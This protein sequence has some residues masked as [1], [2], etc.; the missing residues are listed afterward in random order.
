MSQRVEFELNAD[1]RQAVSAW[2]AL[3]RS[4]AAHNAEFAK[5]GPVTQ[6]VTTTQGNLNREMARAE[7]LKRSL[8][9][10]DQ[11]YARE[12]QEIL[13]LQQLGL[14]S[15]KEAYALTKRLIDGKYEDVEA[16]KRQADEQKRLEGVARQAIQSTTTAMERYRANVADLKAAKDAGKLTEEQYTRAIRQ[17]REELVQ[18]SGRIEERKRKEQEL[19]AVQTREAAKLQKLLNDIETAEDRA[20]RKR[21]EAKSLLDAGKISTDQY[22]RAVEKANNEL[23]AAS[24]QST[25]FT[26]SL[27]SGLVPAVTGFLSLQTVISGV[28]TVLSTVSKA[29][30]EFFKAAE[31]AAKKFDKA[32]RSFAIQANL[33]PEER[34][35]AEKRAV[36]I[37]IETGFTREKVSSA[38]DALASAGFSA[39]EASG[40][41]L[42]A[43]LDI[44]NAQGLR[45]EDPG[46][47]A[48]SIAQFL[49]A[50]DMALT[51]ENVRSVGN[52]IQSFGPD[53]RFKFRDLP[54]IASIAPV[55][56]G[57]A[58]V[59]EQVAV[60]AILSRVYDV[61]S[62][63]LKTQE[64]VN[65]LSTASGQKD[66]RDAL[67]ELGLKP[68]DV[69][70]I[71]EGFTDVFEKLD[72]AL[73]KRPEEDR[74]R[75]LKTLVEGANIG[76]FQQIA[77]SVPEIRE[78]SATSE[79]KGA[80]LFAPA[81]KVG[82]ESRDAIE[83]RLKLQTEQQQAARDQRGDL[84]RQAIQLDSVQRGEAPVAGFLRSSI[85]DAVTNLTGDTYQG[86]KFQAGAANVAPLLGELSQ[87]PL[88]VFGLPSRLY[89]AQV[90]TEKEA[91]GKVS[92]A[93]GGPAVQRP[94]PPPQPDP[95][96]VE[97]NRLMK[98]QNALLSTIAGNSRPPTTKPNTAP[99]KL[100]AGALRS[101]SPPT[102]AVVQR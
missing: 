43:V 98:E 11:R 39:Q 69:D 15:S 36:D 84:T 65:N 48:E 9:D 72:T 27:V 90:D 56:E 20:N 3:Q 29:N 62:A 76:V 60:P 53:T 38:Q 5:L 83:T 73:Q 19:A 25:S 46:R 8:E 74:T 78:R 100:P 61:N 26:D 51:E 30:A 57:K 54:A 79:A 32:S 13:K 66:R 86:A 7:Q 99:P 101:Q 49:T 93:Y 50:N 91:I 16:T 4:V 102:G 44:A 2:L 63:A 82:Q 47:A 35:A 41:S 42:K 23:A 22:G 21:R 88:A 80:E 1:E 33:N 96:M 12:Q 24:G 92:A 37:G 71:G 52:Q 89:Q 31:E 94:T 40:G 85:Y 67:T 77:K 17:Q 14:L 87:N 75:L 45:D 34:A 68:E 59:E 81:V 28:G 18:G 70:F 10:A 6:Q 58:T 55:L 64:I 97:Q 95:L